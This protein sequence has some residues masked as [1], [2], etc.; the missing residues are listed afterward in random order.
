M[1]KF[2]FCPKCGGGL[3]PRGKSLFVCGVCGFNFYQNSKPTASAVII[4]D[5]KVL[6]GRRTIEPAK[7][8]WNVP[9][10]FLEFG[11]DP[12]EAAKREALEETGLV[13]EI[14]DVLG[15]FMDVYGPSKESTLNIAYIASVIGGQEKTD[16]DLKE[17][18][19][20]SPDELPEEMAFESN[21]K[22]L[23]A[24]KNQK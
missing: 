16:D 24:W 12:K 11:E 18:C 6:L 19:W 10:G 8:K 7:G 13:V 2:Q 20:F 5:G 14:G 3:K 1:I 4:K 9:G 22:M 15:I 21:V 23:E 17:L